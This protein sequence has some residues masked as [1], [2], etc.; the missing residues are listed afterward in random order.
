MVETGPGDYFILGQDDVKFCKR[1]SDENGNPMLE[2]TYGK[3]SLQSL[4]EQAY[5]PRAAMRNRG[6][7]RHRQSR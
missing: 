3:I 4:Q 7:R 2:T 6:K 1:T 5:N